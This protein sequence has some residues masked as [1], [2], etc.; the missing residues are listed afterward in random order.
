MCEPHISLFMLAADQVDVDVILRRLAEC[1]QF[2]APFLAYGGAYRP[3]PVGA[4]EL[5][6]RKSTDWSGL[7]R[8]VVTAIEPVRGDRLREL[9]PTGR[10]IADLIAEL[11]DADPDSAQLR[12]L[13]RYGYDEIHDE[14]GDRFN[15]HITLAWPAEPITVPLSDL[16]PVSAFDLEVSEVAAWVMGPWG[17]CVER[18]GAFPLTGAV[19]PVPV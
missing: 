11:R 10:R 14:A 18:L 8:A 19:A 4:P 7:Q 17:T 2:R 9:D 6:F 1:A 13:L 16:P 5:H 12:Q 3:N 15:P